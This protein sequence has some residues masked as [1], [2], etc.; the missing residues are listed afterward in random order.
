M[1]DDRQTP[2]VLAPSPEL[3]VQLVKEALPRLDPQIEAA[4]LHVPRQHFLPSIPL[5][6]VYADDAI[7]TKVSDEGLVLSSSSQPSMMATMIEQLDLRP[8]DNVLEIGAGTGYN[9]AIIQHIVG[10]Y[11]HVTSVEID[12]EVAESARTNLQHAAMGAVNIVIGDGAQGYAPRA[13]YD[14][15]LATAAISDIPRA[16]ARQLRPN[17]R[18]VAPI[19]IEGFQISAG[20]V[21]Q[22]D[23]TLTSTENHVC[24]FVWMQGQR[25]SP[26]AIRVPGGLFID[27][28]ISMDAAAL[29]HLLSDDAETGYIA[30]QPRWQ[31]LW[32]GFLP[33]LSLNLPEG[34]HV[35]SFHGSSRAYGIEGGGF[36]LFYPGSACF[37]Q[38]GKEP[39]VRYF[40]A[41]ETYL[42]LQDG[43]SAW[44]AAGRPDHQHLR[45]R[46]IPIDAQPS[47][48]AYGK[49]Y[50]RTDHLLQVWLET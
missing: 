32:Q 39:K 7:P 10:D 20:L 29:A 25:S 14:R 23:G 49:V 50:Q 21:A 48:E 15:I 4:F 42:A 40:G 33:Y 24:A 34:M 12:P 44:I 26:I 17:G 46:L 8:G 19:W 37:V 13:A 28:S 27:S 18:L 2:P 9:A 36:A 16:W 47:G 22:R 30:E 3:L 5:E 41:A 43:L 6:Q 1:A 35:A 38:L 31:A 45:L 11:G